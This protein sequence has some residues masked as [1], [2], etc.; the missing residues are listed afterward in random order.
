MTP[1]TCSG[2]DHLSPTYHGPCFS[3]GL[4]SLAAAT[5]VLSL[6]ETYFPPGFQDAVLC[7]SP[8]AL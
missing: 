1:V 3:A 8:L 7:E 4:T 2:C 5:I 6:L